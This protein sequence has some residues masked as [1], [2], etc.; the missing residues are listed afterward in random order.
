MH[1]KIVLNEIMTCLLRKKHNYKR[2]DLRDVIFVSFATQN[3]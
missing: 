2:E 3:S 1:E